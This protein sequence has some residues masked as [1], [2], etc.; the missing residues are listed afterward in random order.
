M[1]G[2]KGTAPYEGALIYKRWH[3]KEGRWYALIYWSDSKRTTR[4]WARYLM[5]TSLG[6]FLTPLEQ[7][8]HIDNNKSND[9]L[10]NLQI[11]SLKE[12]VRKSAKP[13]KILTLMCDHCKISFNRRANKVIHKNNK[14]NFCSKKCGYAYMSENKT[15]VSPNRQAKIVHGTSNAYGYHKCRCD[16]CREFKRNEHRNR[17]LKKLSSNG[18]TSLGV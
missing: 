18:E 15:S 1:K 12:N 3:K 9:N 5:E 6:R 10:D 11:L 8:D 17:I 2:I 16:I 4:S 13:P 7:V 14:N